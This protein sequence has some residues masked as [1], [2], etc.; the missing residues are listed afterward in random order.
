VAFA[1]W[2]RTRRHVRI[3]VYRRSDS[4]LSAGTA[5][6]PRR[7][8]L[9]RGRQ[10][11]FFFEAPREVPEPTDFNYPFTLLTGR[12]S[13]SQWHTQTRTD[14]S[15]VLRKLYPDQIY[16]EINPTDAE[17]LAIGP[18]ERVRV[19]SRRG[20]VSATAF[21]TNTV[22]AGHVFIPMHYATA[23]ELTFP[24]FDP[25]SRQP[26]YKACA[27]SVRPLRESG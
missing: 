5:S 27:V 16:V 20:Q 7:R 6:V 11:K 1:G 8:V 4:S 17:R 25:F 2:L 14:K 24:A 23:N 10:G 12:G 19:A 3:P 22:Q 18:N 21:I 13:S 9:P 15:A 26:S